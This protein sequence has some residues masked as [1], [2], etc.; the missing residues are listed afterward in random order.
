M[1]YEAWIM[2]LGIAA[3]NLFTLVGGLIHITGRL[4]RIETDVS[5]LKKNGTECPLNLVNLTK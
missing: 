1:S 5:W 3:V 4:T 2:I